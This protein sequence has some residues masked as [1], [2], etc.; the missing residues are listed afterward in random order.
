M[1]FHLPEQARR[2]LLEKRFPYAVQVNGFCGGW[3]YGTFVDDP[4]GKWEGHKGFRYAELEHNFPAHYLDL[5]SYQTESYSLGT[6]SM[7][8]CD[9]GHNN[10]FLLSYKRSNS[11]EQ[12]G[13]TRSIYTRYLKN[14]KRQGESNYYEREKR[15]RTSCVLIDQGRTATFQHENKA[16]VLYRPRE[17]ENER[18]RS[19]KLNVYFTH[20]QPFDELRVG[21]EAVESFP[22]EFDWRQIVFIR[23]AGI[24]L[25]IR[26]LEPAD[27]GGQG[28]CRLVEER[29]HL[30]LSIYNYQG[31]LRDFDPEQMFTAHNGFICEV[32]QATQFESFTDFKKHIAAAEVSEQRD[33]SL[34][35]LRYTSGGDTLRVAFDTKWEQF[36]HKSVNG[37]YSYPER[38]VVTM[39]GKQDDE[40]CPTRIW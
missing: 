13:D 20:F 24:Y 28:G 4:N 38:L 21:D 37:R 7:P 16:I 30:A 15:H 35:D 14:D 9:G 2:I 5:K 23:D 3:H 40:F 17:V 25:A 31:D 27:L 8:F 39:Q 6:S 36:R 33:G 29:D 34:R 11:I 22:Y 18:C 10:C 1:N 26:P 12:R 32:C 19:L